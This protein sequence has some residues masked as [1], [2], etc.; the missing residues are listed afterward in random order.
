MKGIEELT[1]DKLCLVWR[2]SAS[3]VASYT[4]VLPTVSD[5]SIDNG[6]MRCRHTSV[7]VI[8]S[9]HRFTTP[10]FI[11]E[12]VSSSCE[13]EGYCTFF[14]SCRFKR[15]VD[16]HWRFNCTGIV[17]C[18]TV[19]YTER[20]ICIETSRDSFICST[21]NSHSWWHYVIRPSF[22]NVTKGGKCRWWGWSSFS[23]HNHMTNYRKP[24][25]WLGILLP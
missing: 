19:L 18:I 13:R 6:E 4:I 16:D 11:R 25:L 21:W 10:P 5:A 9:K 20:L 14:C 15:V 7:L 23:V 2:Y 12:A 24:S 22:R 8:L 1:D 17:L 3:F